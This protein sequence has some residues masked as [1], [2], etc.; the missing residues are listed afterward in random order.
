MPIAPE[1]LED[2]SSCSSLIS[3]KDP[4]QDFS[5]VFSSMTVDDMMDFMSFNEPEKEEKE[6]LVFESLIL[7]GSNNFED[8][9]TLEEKDEDEEPYFHSVIQDTQGPSI[10]EF[11]K[12]ISCVLRSAQIF[13]PF[14]SSSRLLLSGSQSD[15]SEAAILEI[16]GLSLEFDE[17][18][19][20][21]PGEVNM[22]MSHVGLFEYVDR[23]GVKGRRKESQMVLKPVVQVQKS[24][25]GDFISD[26]ALRVVLEP[27]FGTLFDFTVEGL[28][29]SADPS[30]LSRLLTLKDKLV[31]AAKKKEALDF[32]VGLEGEAE[33]EKKKG[34]GAEAKREALTQFQFRLKKATALLFQHKQTNAAWEV[35]PSDILQAYSTLSDLVGTPILPNFDSLPSLFSS[36]L[37]EV[38]SFLM[39]KV[40]GSGQMSSGGNGEFSLYFRRLVGAIYGEGKKDIFVS[41][42]AIPRNEVCFLLIVPIF[43]YRPL[44]FFCG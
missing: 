42:Y 41:S 11:R 32:Q 2:L 17:A 36:D 12:K 27:E 29:I 14:E 43:F 19:A 8:L 4:P 10:P 33:K 22:K 21:K 31:S 7:T 34:K 40:E 18:S 6:S 38:V 30:S 24:A 25:K 35:S 15:V 39:K 1:D 20:E 9:E 26:L 28:W 23:E 3:S 5:E 44:P 13:L 37:P 16:E